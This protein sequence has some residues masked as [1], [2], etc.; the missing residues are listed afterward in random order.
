MRTGSSARRGG[1]HHDPL[2]GR[3]VALPVDL[4]PE[5]GP[6]AIVPEQ[7]SPFTEAVERAGGTVAPLSGATR[8]LVWLRAGGDGLSELL[9]DHPHIGWVQLPWAGVDGF[10]DTLAEF[11]G[12][13][14]PVWTSAKSAFSD[15]VAEH[16]LALALAIMRGLPDKARSMS[17]SG[18][19]VGISLYGRSVVII[20]AGGIAIELI[21]LLR[22][23][24]THI[25]IVRRHAGD[26]GGAQRTVTSEQ[27]LAV[28]PDADLVVVAA[29]STDETAHLIGAAELAAMK[30]TAALVNIARG[31]LVDSDALVAALNAGHLAGAGLDVTDPEPLPDGHPLWSAP[32]CII[33]SHSADTPEMTEPLLAGRVKYNVTAFLG[34]GAFIGVVDPKA[35]Y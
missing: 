13:A 31:R 27:L 33:T 12:R 28:L 9:R 18:S 10:A 19:K 30:P 15:P 24:D 14:L 11:A 35:G 6:I 5:S 29:A 2:A 1:E 17:W 25:T 20:G 8:G 23:F 21:R 22:P 26:I 4:R 7:R 32:R 16:A 34:D 3:G